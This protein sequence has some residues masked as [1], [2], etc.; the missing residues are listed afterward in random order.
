MDQ[1]QT[2]RKI[3][4]SRCTHEFNMLHAI[5]P[6]LSYIG[7]SLHH[8]VRLRPSKW[9]A[10]H[11]SKNQN[12]PLVFPFRMEFPFGKHTATNGEM[13]KR[14]QTLSSSSLTMALASLTFDVH[15]YGLGRTH[16]Q[17]AYIIV[18][19][20]LWRNSSARSS[21]RQHFIGD[22]LF[23]MPCRASDYLF[24]CNLCKSRINDDYIENATHI[25]SIPF[26]SATHRRRSFSKSSK[27]KEKKRFLRCVRISTVCALFL[28]SLLLSFCVNIYVA[29]YIIV[30]CLIRVCVC[31]GV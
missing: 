31:D 30:S 12:Y 2:E 13:Q 21:M 6:H 28:F 26:A 29:F 24:W 19:T 4:H 5:F 17:R 27:W 8:S 7:S 23:S 1:E 18:Y 14:R 10:N 15:S 16:T 22:G 11:N 20:K 25:F 9:A 3:L